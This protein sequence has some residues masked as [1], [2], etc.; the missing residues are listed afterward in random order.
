MPPKRTKTP[1]RKST[2]RKPKKRAVQDKKQNGTR[3][4]SKAKSCKLTT[5]KM[6]PLID[7]VYL[8]YESNINEALSANNMNT[9]SET[10]RAAYWYFVDHVVPHSHVN[11]FEFAMELFARM[12]PPY[13]EYNPEQIQ[14]LF[15]K[16][17]YQIAGTIILDPTLSHVLLVQ[18][19]GS[20]GQGGWTFPKGKVGPDEDT[21][22]AAIRETFEE[23]S[24]F[25]APFVHDP[26]LSRDPH[27]KLTDEM[28]L[29]GESPYVFLPPTGSP[30]PLCLV[31]PG[32]RCRL[33]FAP[34][35][36]RT[37]TFS[38]ISSKEIS[39]I[40][41]FPMSKVCNPSW[42]RTHLI[43]LWCARDCTALREISSVIEGLKEPIQDN[44]LGDLIDFYLQSFD[45]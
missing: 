42:A 33:Y 7:R 37:V 3:S 40:E 27:D 8:R 38:P 2:P 16:L 13:R 36:P 19:S 5:S 35:V 39:S 34:G 29:D 32:G 12:P 24:F 21:L 4:R 26:Q 20:R 25:V 22:T 44:L 6:S 45:K 9:L 10:L 23:T 18:Q 15:H 1:Q 17:H 28:Q 31:L 41:W 11:E 14:K 30:E 43:N